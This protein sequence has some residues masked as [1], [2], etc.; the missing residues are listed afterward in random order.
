VRTRSSQYAASRVLVACELPHSGRGVDDYE[1]GAAIIHGDIDDVIEALTDLVV[2]RGY[3]E[4]PP[5]EGDD[6]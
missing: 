1:L 4:A 5:T 6:E 2:E 3:L